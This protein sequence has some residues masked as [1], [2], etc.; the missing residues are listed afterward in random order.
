MVWRDIS[1]GIK[2]NI[3]IARQSF[4]FTESGGDLYL[5][6]GRNSDGKSNQH[7]HLHSCCVASLPPRLNLSWRCDE[8][9]KMILVLPIWHRLRLGKPASIQSNHQ[10]VDHP[11][12]S[13]R[14]VSSGAGLL[15]PDLARRLCVSLRGLHQ[16]Q[17]R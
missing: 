9:D 8:Q 17:R 2:G 12:R 16:H 15:R 5:F 14:I 10:R 1:P 3:P 6:G 4:S 13:A 7:D 11:S